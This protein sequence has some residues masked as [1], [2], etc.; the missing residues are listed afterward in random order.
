MSREIELTDAE[1]ASVAGGVWP[2]LDFSLP[3]YIEIGHGRGCLCP[4]RPNLY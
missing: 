1:L 4:G 3:D 2:E